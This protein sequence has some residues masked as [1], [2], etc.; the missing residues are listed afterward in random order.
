MSPAQQSPAHVCVDV[1]QPVTALHRPCVHIWPEAHAVPHA[2]QFAASFCRSTQRAPHKR[3]AVLVHWHA[4]LRHEADAGHVA[5][6]APQ[7]LRSAVVSTHVPLQRVWP[8]GQG[9]APQSAGQ[10][11]H[12]SAPSHMR[13][14]HVGAHAPQS[15]GHDPQ[16][17]PL[18]QL[19][20]PQLAGHRPQSRA[21]ELQFSPA[22]H[23]PSP[24]LGPD[25]ASGL[26]SMP[27]SGRNGVVSVTSVRQRPPS[28]QT[29]PCSS[30]STCC[31]HSEAGTERHPT[32]D[33]AH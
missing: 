2:P 28:P 30:Q 4:P 3:R 9:Q 15:R 8:A 19:P 32:V 21:H 1:R 23:V 31:V 29:S 11:V 24:Q 10:L 18:L 6:H 14:P 22:L 5:P 27:A 13:L 7:L 16:S 20:S 33:V 25:G 26:A 12:D 17:S